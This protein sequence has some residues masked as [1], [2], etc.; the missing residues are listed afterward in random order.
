CLQSDPARGAAAGAAPAAATGGVACE[1]EEDAGVDVQ[2]I[3]AECREAAGGTDAF[4]LSDAELGAETGTAPASSPGGVASRVEDDA[5]PD[6]A[7][8]P[9]RAAQTVGTAADVVKP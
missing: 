2:G 5:V 4:R 7:G 9:E 1:V 6:D 8:V 3:G